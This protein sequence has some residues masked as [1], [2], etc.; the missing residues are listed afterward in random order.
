M[1][2]NEIVCLAIASFCAG[3]FVTCFV[4]RRFLR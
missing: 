4:A 3:V 1:S 2:L